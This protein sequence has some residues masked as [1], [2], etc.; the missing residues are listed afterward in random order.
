MTVGDVIRELKRYPHDSQVG[1]QDHDADEMELSSR[2]VGVE[3]FDPS[4]CKMGADFACNVRVVLRA[5]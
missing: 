2:V 3:P 1:I 4:T 5:G